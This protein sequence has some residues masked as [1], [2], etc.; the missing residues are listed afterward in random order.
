MIKSYKSF[1]FICRLGSFLTIRVVKAGSEKAFDGVRDHP[2][3]FL[4]AWLMLG[5]LKN[6]ILL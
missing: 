1:I 5:M 4:V 6:A 2:L 3:K